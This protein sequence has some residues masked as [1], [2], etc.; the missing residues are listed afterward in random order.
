MKKLLSILLTAALALSIASCGKKTVSDTGKSNHTPETTSEGTFVRKDGETSA[1][2][3]T[4]G[5]A[6]PGTSQ[7]NA[8]SE[9]D[10]SKFDGET[11]SV[12][13]STDSSLPS[14]AAIGNFD[15]SIDEAKII[16]RDG[17][18][19][20]I[21]LYSFKNNTSYPKSF[22][23]V[24]AT[25]VTQNGLSMQPTVITDID[26]IT[27]L[28]ACENIEPGEEINLQKMFVITDTQTPVDVLVYKYGEADGTQIS[29]SFKLN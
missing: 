20:V 16:E 9:V 7:D 15:V 28:A 24:M 23:S 21:I 27:A 29:R 3:D 18:K 19:A 10:M 25:E 22:D 4:D 26:G 12:A 8:S 2:V 5:N 17:N 13:E 1:I 14:S 6:I 11:L